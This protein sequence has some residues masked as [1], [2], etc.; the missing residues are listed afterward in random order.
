MSQKRYYISFILG[1]YLITK[2]QADKLV[3]LMVTLNILH[4]ACL[5]KR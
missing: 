4:T 5:L 2:I 3:S 1:L